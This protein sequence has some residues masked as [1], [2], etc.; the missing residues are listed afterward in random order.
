MMKF[1]FSDKG[2]RFTSIQKYARLKL[3]IFISNSYFNLVNM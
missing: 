3:K 1:A 2:S